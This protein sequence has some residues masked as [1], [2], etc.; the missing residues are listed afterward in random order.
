[1]KICADENISPVLTGLVRETLLGRDHSLHTV[2]DFDARGVDD[3]I[4]VRRFADA[5]GDAIVGA[6]ARMLTRPHEIAAIAET[7]L[8]L[9]I[10]PSQWVRQRKHAQIAFLF[11]WWPR[12]EAAIASAKPGQCLK[13]PWSWTEG[14]ELV[15]QSVDLQRA[16]KIVKKD[17]RKK[18][19]A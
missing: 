19:R 8:R 4:W 18:P 10:L 12:I 7:G 3:Q 16:Q 5:G 1:M 15:R 13:V 2:D 6:D 14:Q 9:I 11:Y 17:H